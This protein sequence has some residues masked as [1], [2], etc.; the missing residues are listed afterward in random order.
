MKREGE[1]REREDTPPA[2][3]ALTPWDLSGRISRV[4]DLQPL[5]MTSAAGCEQREPPVRCSVM[6]GSVY[7]SMTWSARSRNDGGIV[8]PSALGVLRLMTNSNFVGCSI[9]RSAG[10]APFRILSTYV[11]A[12]RKRS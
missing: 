12:R 7:H 6:L 9:G 1:G 10:L 5:S 3:G 8:R 11:A 4:V 2:S